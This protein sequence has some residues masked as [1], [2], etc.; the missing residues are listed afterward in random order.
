MDRH[1]GYPFQQSQDREFRAFFEYVNPFVNRMPPKSDSTINSHTE[2]LFAEGKQRLRHMLA[3]ALSNIH[4]TCDI[5]TPSN[6][7]G[8]LA[9]VAHFTSEK[10]ELHTVT[11][12]PVQLQGEI[13]G[14]QYKSDGN[15]PG[16]AQ[17]LR[18]SQK[19]GLL[20]HGQCA[21]Q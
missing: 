9:V 11:L 4:I 5:W 17:P 13:S 15:R 1:T 20:S 16:C 3:T 12:G 7:F 8:L 19:L 18:D 6:C 2:N 21:H 14:L 10:S